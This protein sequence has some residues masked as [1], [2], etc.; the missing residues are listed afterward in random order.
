MEKVYSKSKTCVGGI[1]WICKP[2][3][4]ASCVELLVCPRCLQLVDKVEV[5]CV[6]ETDYLTYPVNMRAE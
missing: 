5:V 1:V 3:L 4:Y 2:C 6:S